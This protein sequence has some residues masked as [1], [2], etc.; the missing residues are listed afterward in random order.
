[1]W[2]VFGSFQDETASQAALQK[3]RKSDL[4]FPSR[5]RLFVSNSL[6]KIHI[7]KSLQ[8]LQLAEVHGPK[9]AGKGRQH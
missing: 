8:S 6:F 1:M 9:V 7:P 2:S 5:L 4:F 3:Q